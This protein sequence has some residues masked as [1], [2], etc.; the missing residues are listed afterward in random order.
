MFDLIHKLKA[1]W[2]V[3]IMLRFYTRSDLILLTFLTKDKCDTL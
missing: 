3:L 1:K 2:L